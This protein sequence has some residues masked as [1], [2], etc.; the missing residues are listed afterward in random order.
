MHNEKNLIETQD[1]TITC[2]IVMPISKIDGLE[3]DHWSEVLS[4]L[5]DVAKAA[6]FKSDLVSASEFAG[7]IQSR[8][9][10]NLYQ[11][12][13]VIV[14]VSGKNP[15]VMFELGLRLAFDKATIV[16]ID[17]QTDISFDTGPI[18]HLI[19]PRDLRH[20][21]IIIFKEQLKKKI[22]ATYK[23]SKEPDYSTFLKHFG[24]FDLKGLKEKDGNFNDLIVST[25]ESMTKQISILSTT[26]AFIKT[27][28]NMPPMEKF[29][30]LDQAIREAFEINE[31]VIGEKDVSG[32]IMNNY[33]DFLEDKT[34]N[35]PR[36]IVKNRIINFLSERTEV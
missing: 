25:L 16:V 30:D 14:D 33:R 11:N 18:E 3:T 17:D 22:I 20:G 10:Q 6:G 2:G 31:E 4:I 27:N 5:Q 29:S 35:W 28:L 1:G 15:N 26:N 8:I 21:K 24:T 32:F 9:V 7:V 34:L 13:I 23:K 36:A 19:Y 12:E